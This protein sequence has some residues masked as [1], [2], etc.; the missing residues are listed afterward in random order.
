MKKIAI[1]CMLFVGFLTLSNAQRS[2]IKLNVYSFIESGDPDVYYEYVINE[3]NSVDAALRLGFGSSPFSNA[4]FVDVNIQAA[5]RRYLL[6]QWK[7]A[8]IGFFVRP[9]I[10][11]ENTQGGVGNITYKYSAIQ[12]GA[13]AG[14]QYTFK[15]KFAIDLFAGPAYYFGTNRETPSSIETLINIGLGYGF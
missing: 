5:Y 1:T 2:I 14:F 12:L 3:S 4:V 9:V 7:P 11:Y 15:E 6:P 13:T 10:G 8:P